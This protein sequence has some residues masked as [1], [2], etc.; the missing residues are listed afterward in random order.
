MAVSSTSPEHTAHFHDILV[1]MSDWLNSCITS[2][3]Y[4]GLVLEAIFLLF[5]QF[6]RASLIFCLICSPCQCQFS[7]LFLYILS[8]SHLV[9]LCF[10][11]S[12]VEAGTSHP[13]SSMTLQTP[14]ANPMELTITTR[15]T[16]SESDMLAERC[17]SFGAETVTS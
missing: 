12:I 10:K 6:S 16:Q 1:F 9:S 8:Y 17:L 15:E 7:I 2:H 14:C 11:H 13:I 5:L 3:C 4:T